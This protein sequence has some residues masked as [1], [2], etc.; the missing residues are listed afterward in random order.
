MVVIPCSEIRESIGAWLDGEL[1]RPQA[2]I[3][4]GHLESCRACDEQRRQLE[5]LNRALT[6]AL[7]SEISQLDAQALWRGV[8]QR[9]EAKRPW[10]T[11][12]IESPKVIFR[13]ASLAWTVPALILLL[14]GVLYFEAGTPDWV[15]S[16]PRNNFA[17]VESIDAYGRSVALWRETESKT[18]VIWIYQNPESENE[19]SGDTENKGPAF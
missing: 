7:E 11:G 2:D 6:D 16:G 1:S 14:I 18:T 4:R 5:K 8:R 10:Y 19:G 17:T 3:V 15:G 12:L 9:I 13:P